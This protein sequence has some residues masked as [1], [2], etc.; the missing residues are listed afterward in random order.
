MFLVSTREQQLPD[1]LTEISIPHGAK[2]MNRADKA[3]VAATLEKEHLREP[4]MG[5]AMLA[6]LVMLGTTAVLFVLVYLVMVAITP[7]QGRHS[8]P[9]APAAPVLQQ[10]NPAPAP[11]A[12]PATAPAPTTVR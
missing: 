9:P 12:T 10:Q 7:L 11:T 3:K 4:G 5:A 6:I 8:K 2:L 1:I